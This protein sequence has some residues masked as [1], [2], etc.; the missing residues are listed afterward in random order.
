MDFDQKRFLDA[1]GSSGATVRMA[2]DALQA[3]TR[4]IQIRVAAARDEAIKQALDDALG[5]NCWSMDTVAP[6][7][8]WQHWSGRTVFYLDGRPLIEFKARQPD[9]LQYE[10]DLRSRP[11]TVDYTEDVIRFDWK[12]AP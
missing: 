10:Q 11:V 7:G 4:H 2:S 3:A 6:R 9:L 12:A 1:V 5:P 8:S